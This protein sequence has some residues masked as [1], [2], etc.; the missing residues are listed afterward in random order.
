VNDKLER[1]WKKT[2]VA[3]THFPGGTGEKDEE[4]QDKRCPG[5]NSKEIVLRTNLDINS[6]PTFSNLF[7]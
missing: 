1:D 6:R 4:H 2:V 3:Y 5:Q 7:R